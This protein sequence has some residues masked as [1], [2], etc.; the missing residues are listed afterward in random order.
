MLYCDVFLYV[1]PR[2]NRR[3]R[4]RHR[5]HQKHP[6]RFLLG[7]KLQDQSIPPLLAGEDMVGAAKTGS[8]KTLAFLIPVLEVS[9][10]NEIRLL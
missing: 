10:E 1:F 5:I 2:S 3:N 7:G 8:G 4:D 9:K 6:Q